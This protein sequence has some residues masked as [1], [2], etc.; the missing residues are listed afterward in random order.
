MHAFTGQGV[1]VHRKRCRQGLT[2]AG[3]HF[4]NL[5][6]VQ[7]HAAH[8]LYIKVAHF[9]DALGAFAHYGKGLGQDRVQTLATGHAGLEL[10]RFAPQG[11]I[12]QALVLRLQRIDTHNGSPVLLEQTVI[13][14]S[15]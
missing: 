4:C 9:H 13:A 1:E 14:A 6:L 3:T 10:G 15:K 11:L 5:A 2:F 8:E 12:T 7:R